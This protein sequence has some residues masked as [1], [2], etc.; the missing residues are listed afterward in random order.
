MPAI[1]AFRQQKVLQGIP[2]A[3]TSHQWGL[4][5]PVHWEG[6]ISLLRSLG[7]AQMQPKTSAM[8]LRNH[9]P[10]SPILTSPWSSKVCPL[11]VVLPRDPSSLSNSHMCP[12]HF[13]SFS[14]F[15]LP[16]KTID[17]LTSSLY[18]TPQEWPRW[19]AEPQGRW[20]CGLSSTTWWRQS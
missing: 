3:E 17:L 18:V 4:K 6:I 15:P 8:L 2:P 11:Y 10:R 16:S 13:E 12:A 1:Q 7:A 9:K 14:G 20:G 5:G 19:M